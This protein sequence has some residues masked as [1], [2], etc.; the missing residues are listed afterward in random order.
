MTIDTAPGLQA[1]TFPYGRLSVAPGQTISSS[2]GNTTFDQ[3]MEVFASASD[4]ANQWPSPNEGA[5]SW[6]MDS[7]TPWIFRSGAWHG[8][9]VGYLGSGLGPAS[10]TD[11]GA[12][13]TTVASV[14]AALVV[15]RRYRV[16]A[17]ALASQQTAVGTPNITL[18]SAGGSL[19]GGSTIRL[20]TTVSAS[21]GQAV[22]G[23]A[24]WTF[25]ATLASDTFNVQGVTT[26]GVLR[27]GANATQ[28]TVED[29]GG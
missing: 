21:I 27:F 12:T 5:Q 14:A 3:T 17:Q 4:R 22:T 10:Q 16:S 6:L 23:A 1:A 20:A 11:V 19:P 28:M 2:W 24:V 15:G 25:T 9:P 29:I 26:A 13:A 18:S 8:L 7:H